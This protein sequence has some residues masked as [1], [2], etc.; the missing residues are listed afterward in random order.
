MQ[1]LHHFPT[2]IRY[3]TARLVP[4]LQTHDVE[5]LASMV[6]VGETDGKIKVG[7]VFQLPR[8]WDRAWSSEGSIVFLDELYNV[9]RMT[10]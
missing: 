9:T 4:V 8:A 7:K 6:E 2:V 1:T 10:G 5:V 3:D